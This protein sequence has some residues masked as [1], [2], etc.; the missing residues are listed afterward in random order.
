[1]DGGE[2]GGCVE[3]DLGGGYELLS[4]VMRGMGCTIVTLGYREGGR[5]FVNFGLRNLWMTP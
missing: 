5:K 1:M 2:G 3:L 4:Y